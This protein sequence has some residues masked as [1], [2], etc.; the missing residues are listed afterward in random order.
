MDKRMDALQEKMGPVQNLLD[1][2]EYGML[3]WLEMF[4][5]SLCDLVEHLDE[6]GAIQT[7]EER[8]KRAAVADERKCP[9]CGTYAKR[10]DPEEFGP[11]AW[12][13]PN[14]QCDQTEVK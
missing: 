2:R 3:S 13:C 8:K 12:Y 7:W 11:D 14:K 1:N 10:Y 5:N 4:T 6:I 9:K